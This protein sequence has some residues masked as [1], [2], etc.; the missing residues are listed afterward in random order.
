[1][2]EF[3]TYIKGN[4]F[5]ADEA[6]RSDYIVVSGLEDNKRLKDAKEC[7]VWLF[8]MAGR[9]ALSESA[10]SLINRYP[11]KNVIFK[12][13]KQP[14]QTIIGN[15]FNIFGVSMV[16]GHEPGEY[17]YDI[18]VIS[19]TSDSIR[20]KEIKKLKNPTPVRTVQ[21]LVKANDL[22]EQYKVKFNEMYIGEVPSTDEVSLGSEDTHSG[23]SM[24]DM[25]GRLS[26]VRDV[27][28]S[29]NESSNNNSDIENIEPR[30]RLYNTP[31]RRRL[32]NT[33]PRASDVIRTSSGTPGVT[34]PRASDAIRTSSGTPG[35]TPP[36]ASDA[37][38]TSSRTPGL[39]PPR[40]SS[41]SRIPRRTGNVTRRRRQNQTRPSPIALS[42]A[43]R[44]PTGSPPRT[45]PRSRRRII[46]TSLFPPSSPSLPSP[47][48]PP[49][50]QT[51][52]PL[53]APPRPQV[54]RR[55]TP[56]NM[57]NVTISRG[58]QS[59]NERRN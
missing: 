2:D 8:P 26:N 4:T 14:K 18:E 13:K 5:M 16:H 44:S 38:R 32:Y 40:A 34:P 23:E 45:P 31:P 30:R 24:G 56:T 22:V 54:R 36:R 1:M 53:Q 12:L 27:S 41:V 20:N 46:P 42:F 37:I 57:A 29:S 59:A 7:L 48:S 39:T 19:R 47:P 15:L 10:V 3:E 9:V 52:Q 55:I 17:V 25:F 11:T 51:L 50:S 33:P 6:G 49:Q 28:T 58:S 35:V 21:S 43:S